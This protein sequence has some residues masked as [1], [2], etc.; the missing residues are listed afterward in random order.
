MLLPIRK[1]R[2]EPDI[3]V[4]ELADRLA[5]GL[6]SQ[7]IER[8]AGEL[9]RKGELWVIFDMTRV[10]TIDSAGLGLVARAA[11]KLKAS[12]GRLVVAAG[13][14]RVLELLTKAKVNAMVTVCPTV[15]EAA[16]V[17]GPAP[18]PEAA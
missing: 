3:T 13:E 10:D 14:G 8:L 18:P 11:G 12:G 5:L 17:F 6:E 1:R 4:V 16:D 7:G 9:A 15:M 2:I